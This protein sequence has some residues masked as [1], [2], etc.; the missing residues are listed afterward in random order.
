MRKRKE[1]ISG[2]G[3]TRPVL[4]HGEAAPGCGNWGRSATTASVAFQFGARRAA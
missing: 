1:L 3:A 2:G 4:H